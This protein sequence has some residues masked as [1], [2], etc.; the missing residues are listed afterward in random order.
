M[1]FKSL[2]KESGRDAIVELF[3]WWEGGAKKTNLLI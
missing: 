3:C 2:S 1:N